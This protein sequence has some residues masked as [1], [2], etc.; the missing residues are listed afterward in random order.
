MIIGVLSLFIFLF[1]QK[2]MSFKWVG[3]G[4]IHIALGVL[5]LFFANLL[6][7]N[8]DI[9]IPYNLVTLAV[10]GVLGIPGVIALASILLIIS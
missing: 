2:K 9:Y 10:A 1:G 6:G 5:F 3:T 4:M 7:Q 8:M